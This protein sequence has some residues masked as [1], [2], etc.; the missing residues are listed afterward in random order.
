MCSRWQIWSSFCPRFLAL[1]AGYELG[2]S[3]LPWAQSGR[4][5]KALL[6]F[7]KEKKKEKENLTAP[8]AIM[9]S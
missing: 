9:Q 7:K 8:N 6:I 4:S 5:A 3:T 2:P 1:L